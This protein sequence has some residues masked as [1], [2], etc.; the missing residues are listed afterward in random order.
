M[1][2]NKEN[3]MCKNKTNMT[4]SAYRFTLKRFVTTYLTFLGI[5]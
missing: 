1:R 2:D 5:S 4:L 3:N